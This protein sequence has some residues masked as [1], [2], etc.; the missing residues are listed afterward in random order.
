[1]NWLAQPHCCGQG[2]NDQIGVSTVQT[3]YEDGRYLDANPDWHEADAPFKA[4]WIAQLLEENGIVAQTIAEVGCGSGE[5]LVNLQKRYPTASFAGYDISSQA[6][7][8]CKSKAGR[9]LSFEH[10]DFLT[11][12][13]PQTDVLLA[14]DVFEHVEDYMGFIRKLKD[15]ASVKVFHIPLDLSVQGLLRGKPLM[16]SRQ[17]VGHLHY[18]CKDTAL[19]TLADCGLEIVSWRYTHGAEELPGRELRTRILNLPRK[20][21]RAINEDFAVRLFGGA[22]MMV[23]TK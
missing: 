21:L 4:G 8:I 14:I 18:F 6:Y 22:S 9:N 23:L 20:L 17:L 7:A 2:Q 10:S 12:Q 1:M 5:I 15:R 16:R 3:I 13:T 19:A 11:A